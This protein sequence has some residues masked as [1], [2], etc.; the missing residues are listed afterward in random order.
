MT[1]QIYAISWIVFSEEWYI[2]CWVHFFKL[3]DISFITLSEEQT[4]VT[5]E[6]S[7]WGELCHGWQLWSFLESFHD[8]LFS[9]GISPSFSA[10]GWMERD[11]FY[12]NGVLIFDGPKSVLSGWSNSKLTVIGIPWMLMA[13]LVS[14]NSDGNLDLSIWWEDFKK[15]QNLQQ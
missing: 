8:S 10:K 4:K 15:H 9:I 7:P 2:D 14:K 3:L 5:T 1:S 13:F 11:A 6:A 12:I